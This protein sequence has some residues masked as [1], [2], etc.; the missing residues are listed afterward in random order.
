MADAAASMCTKA[1]KQIADVA[2]FECSSQM[3]VERSS[4]LGICT[5]RHKAYAPVQNARWCDSTNTELQRLG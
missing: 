1:C 3:R 4:T 2:Q 5:A